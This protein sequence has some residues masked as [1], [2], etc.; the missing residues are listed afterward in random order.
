MPRK[1]GGKYDRRMS[2]DDVKDERML[3]MV[4]KLCVWMGGVLGEKLNRENLITGIR[5]DCV[6][7]AA[8]AI[9]R[10][11][12]TFLYFQHFLNCFQRINDTTVRR[13]KK[14]MQCV[15]SQRKYPYV[16]M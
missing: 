7:S 10:N 12:S 15:Y 11:K 3:V 6:V 14:I 1:E 9:F 8:R 13:V 4:D 5:Y 16:D 2:F